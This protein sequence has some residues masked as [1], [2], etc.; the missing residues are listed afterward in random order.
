MPAIKGKPHNVKG[1]Q[2]QKAAIQKMAENGGNVSKAMREVGY[3]DIT[4]K[5]PKKLT[6]S[7]GFKALCDKYG[8]TDSLIVE[9]LV[10]DIKLKPQKRSPELAL[11]AD[12]LGLRKNNP[13]TA[14][15]VNI[16]ADRAKYE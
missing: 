11:G 15:Q 2:K 1:T 14:I 5:T 6:E 13:V 12:I 10:Q 16:Q 9:S 7:K 8:L 3:T 4:A